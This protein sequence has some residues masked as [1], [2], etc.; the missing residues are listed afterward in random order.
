MNRYFI[1]IDVGTGSARAGIFDRAGA[2]VATAV[3]DIR[4]W[5]DKTHHAEQSGEDIWSAACACVREA[6]S[7]ASLHGE[8]IAGVGFDATC[9]LVV[10]GQDGQ[11]LPVG[12]HGDANRN[13]IVWM[14]HRATDQARRI[15][16]TRHKVL[17]FVGGTISPEMETPKLLWLKENLPE[18]YH[19]AWQ[20][21][22]LADYLTWRAS[23]SLARS[24]C[25]VTCKWTYLAHEDRWDD[26]YFRQVGLDD[27]ADEYF[28]RI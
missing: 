8:D 9:S 28:V 1:G 3:R 24:T 17:D 13:I 16:E 18:T 14:D 15:N 2:M 20:F 25:T 5:Q 11:P 21:F 6:L 7:T 23:G 12:K 22:D 10:L 4:M 26:T 27:L 19:K